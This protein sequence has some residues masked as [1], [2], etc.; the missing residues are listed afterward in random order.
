MLKEYTLKLNFGNYY[1]D[2]IG[3]VNGYSTEDIASQVYP[4]SYEIMS[5]RRAVK[6]KD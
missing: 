6:E 4:F 2:T 1:K 5:V 3:F